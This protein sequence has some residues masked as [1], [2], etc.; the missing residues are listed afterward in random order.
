MVGSSCIRVKAGGSAPTPDGTRCRSR[1]GRQRTASGLNGDVSLTGSRS[2]NYLIAGGES[3]HHPIIPT[4]PEPIR[5]PRASRRGGFVESSIHLVKGPVVS[6][7]RGD[8]LPVRQR[9][10]LRAYS[11]TELA[12]GDSSVP[13]TQQQSPVIWR[14]SRCMT[15]VHPSDEHTPVASVRGVSE[16]RRQLGTGAGPTTIPAPYQP[17]VAERVIIRHRLLG[18]ASWPLRPLIPKVLAPTLR[19]RAIVLHRGL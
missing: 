6:P 17:L 10:E 19:A 7:A 13:G 15:L 4:N 3:A 14:C 18:A 11:L 1:R 9:C 2:L 12:K 5:G 16:S 8:D